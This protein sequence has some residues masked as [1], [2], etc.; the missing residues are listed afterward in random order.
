MA[1]GYVREREGWGAGWV[2][3]KTTEAPGRFGASD[4]VFLVG[5]PNGIRTRVATLRGRR[6]FR[7]RCPGSHQTKSAPCSV[8]TERTAI[9]HLHRVDGTSGGT[10]TLNAQPGDRPVCSLHDRRRR[11]DCPGDRCR[12]CRRRPA[13]APRRGLRSADF[14]NEASHCQLRPRRRSTATHATVVPG[15][16]AVTRRWCVTRRRGAGHDLDFEPGDA[17]DRGGQRLRPHPGRPHPRPLGAAEQL[18]QLGGLLRAGRLRAAD[19]GL[20][21]R[22]G[23]GGSGAGEPGRPRQEDLEADR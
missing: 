9:L 19:P 12:P 13:R 10:P 3:C 2:R 4:L 21:G 15:S 22:S 7:T 11:S 8:R 14:L 23:N 17:G 18:G 5:T 1:G 16:E 6:Q 20:A